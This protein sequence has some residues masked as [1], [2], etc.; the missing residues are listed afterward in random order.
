M[1]NI[2]NKSPF[3]RKSSIMIIETSI[4][5][6]YAE[7]TPFVQFKFAPRA[8]SKAEG[9]WDDANVFW[10][11]KYIDLYNFVTGMNAVVNGKLEKYELKNP[12]TGVTIQIRHSVNSAD[13]AEYVLFGFYRGQ[14]VKISVSLMKNTEYFGLYSYFTNLLTN[15]NTVCAISLMRNDIWFEF[16]GKNKQDKQAGDGG[17]KN[18]QSNTTKQYTP[19]QQKQQSKKQQAEPDPFDGGDFGGEPPTFGDDVPF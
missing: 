3:Y 2:L 8:D 11:T 9:Q 18:K 19:P 6:S 5:V 7:A 13:G 16:V 4:G 14:D 17:Y 1:K 15:Y 10:I 12:K